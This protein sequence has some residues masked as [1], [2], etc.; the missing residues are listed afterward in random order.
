MS[1]RLLDY[2]PL[3]GVPRRSL[4]RSLH[5]QTP[6]RL[7]LQ[8]SVDRPGYGQHAHLRARQGHRAQR[9]LR[10][11]GAG[12]AHPRRQDHRRRRHGGQEHAGPHARAH[13]RR[14]SD[15]GRRH[16]RLHLH[17]EDAAVLHQQGARQ[18]HAQALTAGAGVRAVRLDAGRAPRDPRVRRRR[19]CAQRR[20]RQRADG[21]RGRRRPAGA[22][23]ARLDGAGHRRRHLRSRGA[24]AERHRLRQLRAHRRRS[25]RRS[26][27]E[28]RAPQLRHPHRRGHRRAHQ[29]RDRL[30][31]SRASRCASCR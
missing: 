22:R 26:D 17:R 7:F 2:A 12:R 24:V 10:G 29:D 11:R 8:R 13:H 31:L 20:D 19:R 5:V 1:C 21:R 3:S 4:F 16:R 15:E 9:A 27:H 28:L 6:A 23:G 18:P 25:L 14:A 30:G